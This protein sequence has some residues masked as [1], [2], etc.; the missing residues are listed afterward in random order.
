MERRRF[1]EITASVAGSTFI[2]G[3]LGAS[4]VGAPRVFAQTTADEAAAWHAARRFADSPFGRIAYVEKGSGDAALF[5]HG[6]PLNGFQWRGALDRLS[7][8]RRCIA[9]DLLGLGY[10]DV[11]D[12]Q[13]V[14]PHDQLAMLEW[15]LQSLGVGSVDLVA[16][17]SGGA[18]AQLFAAKHPGRV[19]SILL[20][21]CDTE[22]DSPPAALLP[23][24]AMA[25]DGTWADKFLLPR[26]ADKTLA[27]SK[28]GLGVAYT[29]PDRLTDEAID[30]YVV[31]LVESPRR[32]ALVN[33]Y[34]VALERNPLA[35]IG[36]RLKKV[37]APVR[38]V[39]GTGDDIF[40]AASP[41]YLAKLFP[42]SRGVR[43][44]EGAKLFFP[45]EYPDLIA[46]ELRGLWSMR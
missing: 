33:A 34:T 22:P 15:L 9:P 42:G 4:G 1:L 5:V 36:P 21:N 2:A 18:V 31:P 32:K 3:S 26:I 6:F 39:W 25:R 16:N 27:R 28:N 12:G 19:R 10:T 17:D 30:V 38:V 8:H 41:H 40:S 20:T 37:K 35:G 11:R 45:E 44:V 7:L 23:L 13:P 14:A 29:H 43:L 46:D 24:I